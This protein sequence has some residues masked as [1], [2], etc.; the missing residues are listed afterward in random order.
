[1]PQCPL[2]QAHLF[3]GLYL[4]TYMLQIL[5]SVDTRVD[6]NAEERTASQ[7]W[8]TLDAWPSNSDF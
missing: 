8:G 3:E 4:Q 2:P 1:M 7:T 6:R 5:D